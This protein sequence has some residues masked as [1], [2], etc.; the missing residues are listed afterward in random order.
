MF[1]FL[2]GGRLFFSKVKGYNTILKDGKVKDAMKDGIAWF[3]KAN[4]KSSCHNC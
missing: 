3:Y 4:L 1:F 2:S